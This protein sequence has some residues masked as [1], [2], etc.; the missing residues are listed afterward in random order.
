[1]DLPLQVSFRNMDHSQAIETAVRERATKMER[2]YDDITSCRVVV[3]MPHK[4]HN[5]GTIYHV[6]I[7]I[8]MP[9]HPE[10]VVSRDPAEAHAH[11]DV[12]VTIR[13][14]FNA[15]ERQ[16]EEVV[17]RRQR[18]QRRPRQSG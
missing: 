5:K 10:L 1:M 15:A 17:G 18:A 6:R 4:Q 13:D 7:E 8:G 3:E 11:E 14:A 12:M 16:V 9:G 2:R